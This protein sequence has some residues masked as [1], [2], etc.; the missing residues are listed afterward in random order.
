M[1]GER[2][3]QAG[4]LGVVWVN[5]LSGDSGGGNGKDDLHLREISGVVLKSSYWPSWSSLVAQ[6]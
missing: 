2:W 5:V 1:S 3:K 6:K 4:L